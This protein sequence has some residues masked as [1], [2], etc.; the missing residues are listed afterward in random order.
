MVLR[1]ISLVLGLLLAADLS[2]AEQKK[3]AEPK[4]HVIVVVG[5]GG[6]RE[7]GEKFATW[8]LRVKQVAERAEAKITTIGLSD[9]PKK[10][11][12]EILQHAL[13]EADHDSKEDLWLV[14]IGHG[15]FNGKAAKFNLRGRDVTATQLAEWLEQYTRRIAIINC[16]SC[17]AP[18]LNKLK[19]TNRVIISATKSGNEITFTRFGDFFTSALEGKAADLDKDEQVS[20]LEMFLT[21]SKH[22]Y[23]YYESEGELATEHALIDDNGDGLGSR[24]EWFKGVRATK[25]SSSGKTVDGYSAHQIHLI[26]SEFEKKL[27]AELR[28]ER[29]RLEMALNRHR[30][31]KKR[32]K[33]EVYYSQLE[34]IL[35]QIGRIYQQAE[36]KLAAEK[37]ALEEKAEK[38]KPK[39]NSKATKA[40]KPKPAPKKNLGAEPKAKKP[41]PAPEAKPK[42]EAPK[43]AAKDKP[44]ESKPKPKKSAD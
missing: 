6:E 2:A 27:S 1:N 38:A 25:K 36:A 40:D 7:Y 22:V 31:R 26:R 15:T 4:P 12:I 16:S 11:D 28:A 29:D 13:E 24:A 44:A 19:A 14:L 3:P 30:D 10:S 39:P 41:A 32:M 21:A 9:A 43:P 34:K 37:K 17:S 8:A 42:A 23:A 35:T 5:A 18:F 33:E 20:L